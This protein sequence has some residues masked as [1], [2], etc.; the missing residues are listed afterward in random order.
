MKFLYRLMLGLGLMMGVAPVTFAQL[1]EIC[2]N[3]L[4]DDGDG[5]IDVNDPDCECPILEP[6][7][8]IPNPSFEEQ[9]CC[10]TSRSQMD[11][12]EDWI[13][14]SEATT[15]YLHNCGWN[16][17][18][19]LPAPR[20]FP[21][22]NA[23]IGFRNG[24]FGG[25]GTNANWKEYT[26]AC[27]LSPLR[28]G[29][30]YKF[31]FYIGF[32]HSQF[33]PALDVKFYGSTDC[34]NLPFGNGDATF[35]CPTNGP[36][37]EELGS[38]FVSGS[39]NWKQVE[40]NV[41]PTQ[42]IYAITIGP[43]CIE[44]IRSTNTYYFFD[45]LILADQST[46]GFDIQPTAH[47][48]AEDLK[49]NVPQVDTL[50]YQWYKEGIA[51]LGE[52][53]SELSQMYG[54]GNYQVRVIGPS[55]NC[56][57]TEVYQHEKPVF[58]SIIDTTICEGEYFLFDNQDL[59]EPGLYVDTLKN[60]DN[61][62]SVVGLRLGVYIDTARVEQAKIFP[63]ESYELGGRKY[64]QPREYEATLTSRSG[65]DSTILLQLE[66]Y[67]VYIPNAFSPNDDG[68]NDHFTIMGSEDLIEVRQLTIYNRWGTVVHVASGITG[69]DRNQG[70]DGQTTKGQK[71][72]EGVY[73]FMAYIVYDDGKER[74]TTGSLTLIR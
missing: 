14:A 52:E 7:S 37:W 41:T 42:D 64:Y 38:V 25:N 56:R 49:I 63:G 26:G 12:A 44:L 53:E 15:D 16:G 6:I 60:V 2:D 68:I 1:V 62:D 46:F 45:N 36:G 5:L 33:S 24:R 34:S 54:E 59:N 71:A 10:P 3:A 47:P 21:D 20:P 29:L 69:N 51:L 61:C 4:D 9:N 22:G 13:Q 65:C 39:F 72:Q 50:M 57:I 70:W 31:Q 48:C 11:C 30:S 73:V 8:L 17:W 74:L 27:L 19:D 32:T 55:G 43:D 58:T 23:C 67:D 35:G 18:D 28:A 40:I 66:F